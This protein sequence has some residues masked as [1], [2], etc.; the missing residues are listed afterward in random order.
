MKNIIIFIAGGAVLFGALLGWNYYEK[1]FRDAAI[2]QS[3][4]EGISASL[5][6]DTV[7]S[8]EK[9]RLVFGFYPNSIEEFRAGDFYSD[10]ASGKCEQRTDF[11][12]ALSKDK[13]TYYIFSKGKDCIEFTNDDIYPHLSEKEMKNIGLRIPSDNK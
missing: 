1:N 4:G 12:Y 11:H 3:L 6:R 13:S 9:Y 10:P 8:I 2:Y 7:L 5:L